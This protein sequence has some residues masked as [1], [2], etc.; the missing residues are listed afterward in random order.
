MSCVLANDPGRDDSCKN[1]S[2]DQ[3]EH[4]SAH[5]KYLPRRESQN[6]PSFTRVTIRDGDCPLSTKPRRNGCVAHHRLRCLALYHKNK[7][8]L[9]VRDTHSPHTAANNKNSTTTA[10]DIYISSIHGYH[11]QY[12]IY[13]TFTKT[14]IILRIVTIF[15]IRKRKN[16]PVCTQRC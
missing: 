3:L 6:R 8:L 16:A 2:K 9:H 13:H 14:H 1:K 10:L 11:Q 4:A 12:M 15:F 5:V 7:P